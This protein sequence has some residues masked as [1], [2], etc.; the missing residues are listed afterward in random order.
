MDREEE[1]VMSKKN[2]HYINKDP[3][4]FPEKQ[5]QR[6]SSSVL[7]A[8]MGGGGVDG[9]KESKRRLLGDDDYQSS[10]PDLKSS[11]A[12]NLPALKNQRLSEVKLQFYMG[13]D[14]IRDSLKDYPIAPAGFSAT[15]QLPIP[16]TANQK[17]QQ[18]TNPLNT[19]ES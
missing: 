8:V 2:L 7:E 4:Q 3:I 14:K 6:R 17:P 18:L 15:R 10:S 1:R 13:Q 19:D 11:K 16:S 9:N 12:G 5:M